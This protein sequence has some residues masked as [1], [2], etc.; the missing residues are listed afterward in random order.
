M[1]SIFCFAAALILTALQ[2]GGARAE[3]TTIGRP[4]HC[5]P[6]YLEVKAEGMTRVAFTVETDETVKDPVVSETSGNAH[7]DA[8]SLSCVRHWLYK[9]ANRDGV[10]YAAPWD[11]Y[12]AW[13]PTTPPDITELLRQCAKSVSAK[14]PEALDSEGTAS[15]A[16]RYENGKVTAVSIKQSGGLKGVDEAE[17]SC[18]A[19]T[20][21][22]RRERIVVNNQVDYSQAK[23]YDVAI[24]WRSTGDKPAQ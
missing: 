24:A 22:E 20:E 17:A 19:N 1:K 15:F 11:A 7:V 23:T 5:L 4:H 16:V 10:P 8:A 18:L 21:P 2:A 3:T 13:N 12:I 6:A 14:H 9:P